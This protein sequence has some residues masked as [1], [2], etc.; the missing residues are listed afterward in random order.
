[1]SFL[2]AR[3]TLSR[4]QSADRPRQRPSILRA[5]LIAALIA[6]SAYSASCSADLEA[7]KR[8]Y[9][10]NG[11]NYAAAGKYREAAIEYRNAIQIDPMYGAGRAK[12]AA[13]YEKLGDGS[14]A[15]SEYVRAADL[16]PDDVDLQLTTGRYLMA[17]RNV[18]AA[19]ARADAVLKLQPDNI[20]AHVLR[21]N[22]LGGLNELDKA[23]AEMEEALRL[24]PARGAT[25]TQLALVE[26]ARGRQAAAEAAFKRAIE[27]APDWVNGRLALANFYWA[28][29]RLPEAAQAFEAA[30]RLAPQNESANHAMAVF[31]LATGQVIEAEK[32]LKQLADVTRTPA[33]QFSLAEYYIATRR[34]ADAIAILSPLAGDE[35][36][37]TEAKYRLARAYATDGS[38]NKAFSLVEEILKAEPRNAEVLL[39]KGQ[40]LF[41]SDRRDEAME[42]VRA[43]V[44][45]DPVS[46]ASQFTLGKMYGARGDVV[47]A[48][49]AYREVLKI[50][51]SA[52]AAQTELALLQLS[53]RGEAALA[54]AEAAV[55]NEPRR[56][57]PRLALVRGL[58][59][60]KEFTRAGREIQALLSAF[61]DSAAVHTQ[62]AVLAASRGNVPG[63]KA[64]FEKALSLDPTSLEALGGLLALELNA[65][66]FGAATA[67]ITK[68]VEAGPVTPGLLLLAAR[69]YG[70]AGDL[71]SAERMLRRA[72]DTDP[73]QLSAYT[74]LGQIYLRQNKLDQARAEFDKLAQRQS[75]PVSALTMSGLI[76]QGQG[77]L[78]EAR[79]RFQSA[80]AADSRAAVAANNLAWL[81]TESGENL[82]EAL[83]LARIAA[84][85]LPD[86]PET[87]D[88][89]G[90]AYYK[91]DMPALA[92]APLAQAV[93]KLP[94]SAEYRFH[95]G[96]VFVKTG[97]KERARQSLTRALALEPNA[98]WAGQARGALA[99]IE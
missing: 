22:A 9:V 50:N 68:R 8:R 73:T 94:G 11:D 2:V 57:E 89:L 83:R 28:V 45:A 61:P 51:P 87:L 92:I 52:A 33:A 63:A 1:M 78:A 75:N 93:E 44:A 79:M 46:A 35:R 19:L 20:D 88:T 5:V 58:L 10:E 65:K 74:M 29:G 85:V 95:L 18:D 59:A 90:W 16:L 4:P 26:S 25:Y 32:Y 66:D 38:S 43:A 81:Y 64:T 98:S 77:N 76:L 99:S 39:L 7:D 47:G 67:R 30:L 37:A 72:I 49:R 53:G 70:S 3:R 27:L 84:E 23:V 91:N 82:G 40:L 36:T 6:S 71:A 24:D 15:L 62:S 34:A 13:A 42:S 97:D 14:N 56:L 69:T 80:V 12:L 21:G 17:A 31:S 41:E 54:T 86:A 96:M 48:E 55:K 60:G